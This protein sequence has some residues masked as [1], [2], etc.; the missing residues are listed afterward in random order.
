MPASVPNR[1]CRTPDH[2]EHGPALDRDLE[3]F[4]SSPSKSSS[5][6]A[7][8]RWP[9]E[10]IGRNSVRPSTMPR[11]AALKSSRVSNRAPVGYRR[12]RTNT[13]APSTAR[14]LR[15]NTPAR[16][17]SHDLRRLVGP[18][19]RRNHH[20]HRYPKLRRLIPPAT[21]V[22]AGSFEPAFSRLCR[23]QCQRT[24]SAGDKV[25]RLAPAAQAV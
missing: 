16:G 2:R 24:R 22:K 7:T 21:L 23:I 10:E 17:W 9:V 20:L 13:R 6:A 11:I 19:S 4:A 3:R 1:R 25:P 14:T 18:S 15:E 8:I 12:R 5:D